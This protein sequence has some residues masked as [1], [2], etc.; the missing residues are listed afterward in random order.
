M[1]AD[2]T[3]TTAS[4]ESITPMEKKIKMTRM[5]KRAV[6]VIG[7]ILTAVLAVWF[8][9][10]TVSLYGSRKEAE[11]AV[12][13]R[14]ET[15]ELWLAENKKDGTVEYGEK[16]Y[17][18]NTAVRAILCIGVDTAGKM[19]QSQVIGSAGQADGIF[20]VAQDMARDTVKILMIPR[21]TM[22]DINLYDLSGNSLGKD[23]QHL[24]LAFAYGDGREKSCELV[25][26][27]VSEL[28]G[29]LKI[30]GYMAVNTSMIPI[31]NDEIG[32]VEVTI[33]ESGMEA[34][35]P[36][37]TKGKTITL[38][39]SQAELFVRYRDINQP[40]TAIGRMSRQMVY[41]EAFIS[42]SKE[43]A[44]RDQNLI[45]RMMNDIQDHMITNMAKDQ[46]MDMGLAVLNSRQSVGNSDFIMLPGEGVETELFD[47][48]HPD[49][50]A[51]KQIVLDLFYK[52]IR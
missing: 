32:G 25:K 2:I 36:E 15:E 35:D 46:Y 41:I 30:D 33:E 43:T 40:Q 16:K 9:R 26:E 5:K 20:L 48:Y 12:S 45:T 51:S 50:E 10:T 21:D 44:A 17:R 49:I 8:V 23:K 3:I 39:G 34:R 24:T 28:L 27:A 31:L 19:E 18:R 13:A 47:E 4:M 38:N 6:I 37:M 52:E 29:G 7:M 1:R 11:R 14:R 22:T 42:K